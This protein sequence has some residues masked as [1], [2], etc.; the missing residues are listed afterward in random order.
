METKHILGRQVSSSKRDPFIALDDLDRFQHQYILGKTGK[1]K[2][3][4]LKN[5]F[6]QDVHA[7]HGALYMDFHGQDA[8]FLLNAIPARRIDDVLYI[9]LLDTN[10]S[11]AYNILDTK[12]ITN[13][14]I[15]VDGVVDALRNASIAKWGEASWGAQLDDVLKNATLPLFEL[16]EAHKPT[17]L[18]VLRMLIDPHYRAWVLKQ[19]T[20]GAVLDFWNGQFRGWS[21]SEQAH[22]LNSS[23]NKIRCFQASEPIRNI[24][25]QP[26]SRID[27]FDVI[28][29]KKIV[30]FNLHKFAIGSDNASMLGSLFLAGIFHAALL[31]DTKGVDYND[32]STF[33]PFF[34]A[35]IDEFHSVTS[36]AAAELFTAA[37]KSFFS[38]TVAHQ[39]CDQI[40]P[41]M[42]SAIKGNVATT[43]CFG[44]GGDDAE[45]MYTHMELQEPKPLV[46]LADRHYIV[47]SKY[48][49]HTGYTTRMLHQQCHHANEIRTQSKAK[50]TRPTGE[51]S[52]K[53]DAWYG[54][55]YGA[56][57]GK[58][59]KA[60]KSKD[61]KGKTNAGKGNA[62]KTGKPMP[63]PIP[64]QQTS[65]KEHK[66]RGAGQ[67]ISDRIEKFRQSRPQSD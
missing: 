10:N 57:L 24:V 17:M 54:I 45:K 42:L 32:P 67:V 55:D 22:N 39:Y 31:R 20:N 9:D 51:V 66:M 62:S 27:F 11:V 44:I 49:T 30:I 33:L 53:I 25:G 43:I 58:P 38:L 28:E 18:S 48:G 4:L 6:L 35:Y 13:H 3:Y 26:H 40:S 36:H 14:S 15:F 46:D 37:R 1:G 23:I 7:G 2:S 64:P 5:Q 8:P 29:R 59:K 19:T 34:H 60:E 56:L 41:R 16:P 65:N 63:I 61:N 12:N 47:N 50:Y 21:K 52:P